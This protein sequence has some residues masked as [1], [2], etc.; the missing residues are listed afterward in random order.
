MKKVVL[1]VWLTNTN[2][3]KPMNLHR[4]FP[5]FFIIETSFSSPGCSSILSASDW[6]PKN[7]SQKLQH[8]VAAINKK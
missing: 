1:V 8:L 7:N 2:P 4:K 6:L 5:K 3:D